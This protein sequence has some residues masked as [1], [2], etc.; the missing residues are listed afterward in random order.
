[1]IEKGLDATA[2]DMIGKYVNMNGKKLFYNIMD[3]K[4]FDRPLW[5]SIDPK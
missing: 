1:M 2:A 5:C 4:V 3:V